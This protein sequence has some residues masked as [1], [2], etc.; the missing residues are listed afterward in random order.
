MCEEIK[1][2]STNIPK[3]LIG[4]IAING[5]LGFAALI[6]IL[7]C[8]GDVDM[9]LES[10]T[11]FPLMEILARA[12]GV[13]AAIAESTMVL[14]IFIFATV[15]CFT[16]ASRMTWAFARDEGLPGSRFISRVSSP[17]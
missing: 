10:P 7:F 8:I 17:A 11:G 14:I 4:A 12:M 2:A 1:D 9:A 13:K 6:A 5:T 15:S 3:S 16:A